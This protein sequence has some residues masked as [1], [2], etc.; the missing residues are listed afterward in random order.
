MATPLFNPM[1]AGYGFQRYLP[2][3]QQLFA[4]DGTDENPYASLLSTL[5]Q[6]STAADSAAQGARGQLDEAYDTPAQQVSPMQAGM[7]TLLGGISQTVAPQL[8]GN[9]MAQQGIEQKNQDFQ[10]AR[11]ERLLRME[12]HYEELASKAHDL[13]K[14]E[15][16]LQMSAKAESIAKK[17]EAFQAATKGA[18]DAAGDDAQ[19]QTT[20]EAAHIAANASME[21]ARTRANLQTPARMSDSA[22]VSELGTY[23]RAL[24]SAKDPT[25]ATNA[26]QLLRAHHF[27][28][29]AS[30][31][32]DPSKY[33][34]RLA[35]VPDVKINRKWAKD[36]HFG[37]PT[38]L[39]IGTGLAMNL[40]IDVSSPEEA[41]KLLPVLRRGL[42]GVTNPETGKPYTPQD[43]DMIVVRLG[44]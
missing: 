15:L 32:K 7:A 5:A 33:V 19:R 36:T 44:Q 4:N 18:L 26:V 30:E 42:I 13:K 6:Q 14:T 39:E 17:R 40:G 25:E 28:M 3:M 43:V 9:A 1:Q 24:T 31:E 21:N 27:V 41:A 37:T 8:Q 16:S 34:G 2:F 20:L 11:L 29:K 12:K 38:G 10:K 23:N 35:R 22:W